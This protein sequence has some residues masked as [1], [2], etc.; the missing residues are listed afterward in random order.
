VTVRIRHGDLDL[1]SP[2]GRAIFDKRVRAAATRICGMPPLTDDPTFWAV[3]GCRAQVIR[4]SETGVALSL[5]SRR[6][7]APISGAR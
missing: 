4:S 3:S 7:D 2:A 5:A 6:G 1:A